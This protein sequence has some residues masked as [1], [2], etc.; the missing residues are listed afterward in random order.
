MSTELTFDQLNSFSKKWRENPDNMVIQASIM[1]NGIK[2]ATE[3][4]VAKVKVQPIFSHEVTTDKVSNQQQSGRCW[5][6]AALNTFR[7]KLNGTLGLKDFE[8]S[9]NYTNF[10]DKLEKANF[11]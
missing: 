1:K 3:N 8:L 5:M 11:F 4:P 2:A 6:F 10:W 7:H 9:Q